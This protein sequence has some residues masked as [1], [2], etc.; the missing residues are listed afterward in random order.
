MKIV[1][2]SDAFKGSLTSQQVGTAIKQGIHSVYPD[3]E[4]VTLNIADGGEGTVD[5]IVNTL[6][7]LLTSCTVSDPLLRPIQAQYG[8]VGQL[9][10]I[11]MAAASG[12]TLLT[13]QE[14]N[15]WITSTY[16]TGQLIADALDKGCREFIIGIGGSAT[17]DAGIGMLQALGFRFFDAQHQLITNGCGGRLSDIYYID[18]S[19]AHKAIYQSS[20]TIACDVD[21]PF[22]G[23]EGV[24]YVF[25]P[26][27]G[28]DSD[29]V[30]LLDKGLLSLA[31][32]IQQTYH[33]DIQSI[34]GAGAAGGMGGICH[35]LLHAQL[36]SGI[37]I[38]LD[39]IQFSHIIQDAQLIITGEGKIDEQTAHGKAISGVLS[40]AKKHQI[41]VIAVGGRVEKC[42]IV[43][44]LGLTATYA[45]WPDSVPLTIAMQPQLA[46]QM[47]EKTAAYI[48]QKHII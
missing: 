27:K 36:K 25:A 19:Q 29:M 39:T 41:P 44:N 16:G 14:R 30:K 15:P 17:N 26:Q 12:I 40:R 22:Y 4:V 35:A 5:A 28:A 48:V 9:A 1:V 46:A 42:Y 7:G 10:I 21:N 2:A 24:A 43:A 38:V 34:A 47:L 20:F 45:I 23:K 18:D 6:G 8:I 33:I 11:E 31:Q 37:E 32:L 13:P 3:C